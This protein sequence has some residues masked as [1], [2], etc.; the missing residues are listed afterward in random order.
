VSPEP[1]YIA[2]PSQKG[3]EWRWEDGEGRGSKREEREM[4][5]GERTE[6][7]L[8]LRLLMPRLNMAGWPGLCLPLWR[9]L[10]E[11]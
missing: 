7:L 2:R 11:V 5:G 6:I 10:C 9:S 3:K 8:G 4:G 1:G